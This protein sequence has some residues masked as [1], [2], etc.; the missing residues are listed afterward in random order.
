MRRYL[1]YLKDSGRIDHRTWR[2]LYNMV[3]GGRF[4]NVPTLRSYITT[5]QLMRE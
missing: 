2:M 3:K 5:N 4:R 1:R